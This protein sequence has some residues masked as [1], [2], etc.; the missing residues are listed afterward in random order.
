MSAPKPLF[1]GLASEPQESTIDCESGVP[2]P[3]R[4]VTWSGA[5]KTVTEGVFGGG[6]ERDL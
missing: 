1:F 5:T 6:K 2:V 4:H 3:V